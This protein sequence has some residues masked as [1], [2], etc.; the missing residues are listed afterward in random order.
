[1]AF[2]PFRYKYGACRGKVF[3]KIYL[4]SGY[5]NVKLMEKIY[6]LDYLKNIDRSK[7]IKNTALIAP[8]LLDGNFLM[9]SLSKNSRK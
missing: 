5:K 2:I 7:I 1:M 9:L 3:K 8:G 6:R 4:S